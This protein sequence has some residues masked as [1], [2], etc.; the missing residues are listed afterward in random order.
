MHSLTKTLISV[1]VVAGFAGA[2]AIGASAP[3]TA[4]GFYF[5]APGIHIGVDRPYHHYYSGPRY[6]DY[7]PGYY[8]GGTYNGCPPHYT[9]QSGVCKPYRGY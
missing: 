9:I 5:N 7:D 1:G 8:G 6:Y 3:A 2:A 4:Q